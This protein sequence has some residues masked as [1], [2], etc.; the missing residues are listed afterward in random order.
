M[1]LGEHRNRFR[2]GLPAAYSYDETLPKD[3]WDP[4]SRVERIHAMGLDEAVMFP[5]FGLLW[6]RPLAES[7]PA[8]K[9]NMN[10]WNRWCSVVVQET[11]GQLHPVAHLSLRDPDWLDGQLRMLSAGGVRLALI[12]P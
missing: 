2:Q 1:A 6:E 10:A 3:Y 9:A 8:L 4:R 12:A 7:L 11:G 5:N